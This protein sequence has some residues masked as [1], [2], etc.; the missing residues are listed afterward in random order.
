MPPPLSRR[1]GPHFQIRYGA[2]GT[3]TLK[4][5]VCLQTV[6]RARARVCVELHIQ[7][8][9]SPANNLVIRI[10]VFPH[11][12]PLAYTRCTS[13]M[14]A[15]F[16]AHFSDFS[17]SHTPDVHDVHSMFCVHSISIISAKCSPM[18]WYGLEA[19]PINKSQL[20]SLNFCGQPFLWET[21]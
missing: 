13:N 1:T 19:L 11:F 10:F 9:T 20:T 17:H 8:H 7:R 3:V 15:C 5:F 14:A 18:L 16:L 6:A 12:N 4:T 21:I 2:T